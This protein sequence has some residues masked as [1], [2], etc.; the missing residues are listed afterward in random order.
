MFCPN[1]GTENEGN[2]FCVNCGRSLDDINM[3]QNVSDTAEI[4]P[5]GIKTRSFSKKDIFN[6]I[7]KR[8]AQIKA[9]ITEHPKSAMIIAAVSAL[10]LIIIFTAASRVHS[11]NKFKKLNEKYD[12]SYIYIDTEKFVNAKEPFLLGET[13]IQCVNNGQYNYGGDTEDPRRAEISVDLTKTSLEPW[14]GIAVVEWSLEDSGGNILGTLS[15]EAQTGIVKDSAV[16]VKAQLNQ[17]NGKVVYGNREVE[18]IVMTS[19]SEKDGLHAFLISNFTNKVNQ[20]QK[21]IDTGQSDAFYSLLESTKAEYPASEF[22]DQNAKL[23]QLEAAALEAFNVP[24]PT[25]KPPE[26]TVNNTP[27]P[28]ANNS[29]QSAATSVEDKI[30]TIRGWYNKTNDSPTAAANEGLT[31]TTATVTHNGTSYTSEQYYRN[32]QL[33]FV[34][35]YSGSRENRLYF[36]DNTMIRWIDEGKTTHDGEFGNAEYTSWQNQYI[37]SSSG[38]SAGSA[39][40]SGSSSGGSSGSKS[41]GSSGN[42]SDSSSGDLIDGIKGYLSNYS[43]YVGGVKSAKPEGYNV[44]YGDAFDNFFSLGR[45]TY[46][47][48]TAGQDI[49]QFKGGCSYA[50][51]DVTACIQFVIYEGYFVAEYLDFNGV[52]Q[53]QF[54]LSVLLDTVFSSY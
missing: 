28:A 4:N 27:A 52:P 25:E 14:R 51:Q 29:E 48:S 54:V 21:Y 53:T 15:A 19:L 42:S 35:A 40:S 47:E 1:C 24:P 6:L 18:K 17:K 8:T 5:A 31:K 20:L 11:Q 37:G 12:F 46:F 22:P 10:I 36:W 26:P 44:T 13:T 43:D 7:G 50:G 30:L 9:C 32:G 39:G 49:V 45:W 3:T 33:Y 16:T 41:G 34:F 38:G 2:K 23:A